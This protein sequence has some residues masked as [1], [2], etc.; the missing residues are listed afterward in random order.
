MKPSIRFRVRNLRPLAN[1]SCVKSMVQTS[2]G[3]T[4]RFSGTR[5]AVVAEAYLRLALRL[6]I[7]VNAM[8]HNLVAGYQELQQE[9]REGRISDNEVFTWQKIAAFAASGPVFE[10]FIQKQKAHNKVIRAAD[11]L[12]EDETLAIF[13]HE[14]AERLKRYD[15][16]F[17]PNN[18]DRYILTDDN[19]GELM[20]E[21]LR[22]KAQL[23]MLINSATI[24]SNICDDETQDDPSDVVPMDFVESAR[25]CGE[26]LE[27]WVEW[28]RRQLLAPVN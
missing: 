9:I 27:Q 14:D 11:F 8:E 16:V 24:G 7:A 5:A 23:S 18:P 19:R 4:G 12:K 2:S 1:A 10:T 15:T 28:K 21:M 20:V 26:E 6:G 17:S 3:D 13:S 22:E 25:E